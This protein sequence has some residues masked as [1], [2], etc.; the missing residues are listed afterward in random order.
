MLWVPKRLRAPSILIV[1]L[2]LASLIAAARRSATGPDCSRAATSVER[3]ICTTPELR[4]ADAAMAN[5]YSALKAALPRAQQSALLVD[6]RDWI[7][8]RD[9]TCA[10]RNDRDL[11]DCLLAEIDKRRRFLAGEGPNRSSDAPRLRPVFFQGTREKAFY[12]N[13]VYPRIPDPRS[14][15]ESDFNKAAQSFVPEALADALEDA[16]LRKEEWATGLEPGYYNASY[17]VS[18]LD[19]RL[20][21][22]IFTVQRYM[23]GDTRPASRSYSTS[24]NF[25]LSHGREL[26]MADIVS[27]PAHAVHAIAGKCN[28]DA[29]G[30]LE[31]WTLDTDGVS[32]RFNDEPYSFGFDCRLSWADLSPWLKP[33]GPLPPR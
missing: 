15:S 13:V 22:V 11:V 19:P 17:E 27:S 5:A 4:A 30:A 32:I 29:V 3:A 26:S 10:G 25:D 24:L 16:K 14:Q 1:L 31:H 28:S 2:S 6:Q 12:I 20:A 9:S 18:Y 33:G 21:S 8:R 23:A 7:G